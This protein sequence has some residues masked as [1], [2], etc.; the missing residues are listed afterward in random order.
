MLMSTILITS[1]LACF[2]GPAITNSN[3]N[4]TTHI[5]AQFRAPKPATGPPP[6][7]SVSRAVS[8][9]SQ[10]S[11]REAGQSPIHSAEIKNAW[12]HTSNP[13]YAPVE[14]CLLQHRAKPWSSYWND[15]ATQFSLATFPQ[16]PC[17]HIPSK[18]FYLAATYVEHLPLVQQ[19]C[20]GLMLFS[21]PYHS[22]CHACYCI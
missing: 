17:A 8:P 6:T 12:I 5:A 22:R 10:H 1:P 3:T 11:E 7:Q 9:T 13:P 20:A 19:H 14:W 2:S 18:Y 16:L 4:M 15:Y 21:V